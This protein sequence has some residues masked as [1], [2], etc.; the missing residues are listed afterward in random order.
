MLILCF[1]GAVGN[2]ALGIANDNSLAKFNMFV[3]GAMFM[4]L[5]FCTK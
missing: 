4:A 3:S 1:I 2:L 5:A